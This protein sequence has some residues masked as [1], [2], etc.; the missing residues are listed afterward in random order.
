MLKCF[1]T[2]LGIRE[3]P[4]P[5][6]GMWWCRRTIRRMLKCFRTVLARTLTFIYMII[7]FSWYTCNIRI[8]VERGTMCVVR[9]R[10]TRSVVH[11]GSSS[12][13]R[14]DMNSVIA[15]WTVSW[16]TGVR[17]PW[18]RVILSFQ[19]LRVVRSGCSL[20]LWYIIIKRIKAVN[21]T[22]GTTGSAGLIGRWYRGDTVKVSQSSIS[23]IWMSRVSWAD[24][25]RRGLCGYFATRVVHT[26]RRKWIW[27]RY[28]CG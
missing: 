26:K 3:L 18:D 11:A 17:W 5:R 14:C 1:R 7:I 8:W 19:F 27:N 12:G 22:W 23:S 15:G 10:G 16:F 9:E 21:Q 25:H 13:R 2:V 6:R 28:A 20:R 4:S 24:R